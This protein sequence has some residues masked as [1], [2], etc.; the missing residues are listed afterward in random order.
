AHHRALAGVTLTRFFGLANAFACLGSIGHG[1]SSNMCV[2][3]LA[4]YYLLRAAS[5]QRLSQ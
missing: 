4:A 2:L 1:L 3:K 5:R